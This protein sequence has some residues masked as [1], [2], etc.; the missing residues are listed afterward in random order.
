MHGASGKWPSR[1]VRDSYEASRPTPQ[2]AWPVP[3][4]VCS[5][6]LVLSLGSKEQRK[7]ANHAFF[8]VSPDTRSHGIGTAGKRREGKSRGST[9]RGNLPPAG[10]AAP[11]P[12]MHMRVDLVLDASHMQT[13]STHHY[14]DCGIENNTVGLQ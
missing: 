4:T 2:A 12:Y 13:N 6:L 9:P 1:E 7:T 14:C 5:C 11:V 3:F 8:E 10:W